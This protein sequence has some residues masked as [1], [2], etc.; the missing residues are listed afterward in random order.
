MRTS[1]RVRTSRGTAFLAL[2]VGAGL[3]IG[4]IATSGAASPTASNSKSGATVTVDGVGVV[5]GKPDTLTVSLGVDVDGPTVAEALDRSNSQSSQLLELLK[6]SGISENDIATSQFSIFPN[7]DK[8]TLRITGYHISNMVTATIRNIEG[9]GTVLDTVSRGIGNEVRINGVSFDIDDDAGLI[10]QARAAA[11]KNAKEKATQLAKAAGMNV[12]SVK[13][14]TET[15]YVEP[16][17]FAGERTLAFTDS[18]ASVP[19][20]TGTQARSV[21]VKVVYNV[22]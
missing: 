5:T 21:T 9:A 13:S 14:I 10:T 15:S 17:P 4:S 11:V 2:A 8:D 18:D 1:Q 19:I 22:S 20:S 7:Y 16:I 12:K 6:T 3:G